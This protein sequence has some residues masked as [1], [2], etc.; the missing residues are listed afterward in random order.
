MVCYRWAYITL[1]I[2][3]AEIM[4][5]KKHQRKSDLL[6]ACAAGRLQDVKFLLSQGHADHECTDEA[7][8]TPLHMACKNG[9]VHVVEFLVFEKGCNVN[10]KR[11]DGRTPIHVACQSS[12][13]NVVKLLTSTTMT[14][15]TNIE[16]LFGTA[17]EPCNLNVEDRDGNTPLHI[18]CIQGNEQLY[19][20][21]MSTGQCKTNV[22]NIEAKCQEYRR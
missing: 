3:S 5:R 9:H 19:T 21:L 22:R 18:A 14:L 17:H 6:D 2:V 16:E 8:N 1:I 4:M 15:H 20:L 10:C 7:G 12:Q 13:I 11:R